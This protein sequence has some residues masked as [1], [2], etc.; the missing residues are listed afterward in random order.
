MADVSP[1]QEIRRL[2]KVVA[3]AVEPN[4]RKSFACHK[5]LGER[6]ALW[7]KR[8]IHFAADGRRERGQ[9]AVVIGLGNRIEFMI[10]TTCAADRQTQDRRSGRGQHVVEFVVPLLFD[11][12]F[13]DLRA[14][15]A[16][17]QKAGRHHGQTVVRGEF[18]TGQLPAN[19]G[20][21]R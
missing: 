4:C 16:G 15:H 1:P 2:E 3:L 5:H 10:V 12:V 20:V 9:Q 13:R 21:K 8:K 18:I 17:C 6:R 14:V 11:L 19:E 7:T